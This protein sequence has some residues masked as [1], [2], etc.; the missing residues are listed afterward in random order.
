VE[1][2][3]TRPATTRIR[4]LVA[5]AA[6]LAMILGVLGVAG[7]TGVIP[8]GMSETTSD[9]PPNILVREPMRNPLPS[10]KC[11]LCGTVESIRTLELRVVPEDARATGV[12]G[13]AAARPIGPEKDSMTTLETVAGAASGRGSEGEKN[14]SKRFAYRITVRMDDGSYR[15]ISQP[16]PPALAVGDKVRVVE[17]RLVRT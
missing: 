8:G 3:R 6:V 9:T 5:G 13:A 1:A 7:I 2:N 15:T 16:T 17:G 4:P 10:S 14:V 11:S 12:S